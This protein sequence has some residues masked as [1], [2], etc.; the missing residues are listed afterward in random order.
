[1]GVNLK[2]AAGASGLSDVTSTFECTQF[3]RFFPSVRH[4]A[5]NLIHKPFPITH[6][7]VGTLEVCTGTPA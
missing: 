6:K 5:I 7:I 3:G 1:M 2:Q 4:E